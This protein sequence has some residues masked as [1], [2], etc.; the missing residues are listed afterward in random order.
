M[1][2]IVRFAQESSGTWIAAVG[3]GQRE[4]TGICKTSGAT[5]EQAAENL[6][7]EVQK[8]YRGRQV[9][10]INDVLEVEG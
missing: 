3:L 1:G 8:H 9:N 6:L 2:W 5:K 4:L 7:A 10:L